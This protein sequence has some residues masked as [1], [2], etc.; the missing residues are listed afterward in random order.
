M[1]KNILYSG[2]GFIRLGVLGLALGLVSCVEDPDESDLY[3]FTGETIESFIE[4]DA[5]LT[6]FNYILQRVGMDRMM[7]SYGQYTCFA[8]TNEGVD[9]YIDSLWTDDKAIIPQ[10]GLLSNSLEGLTDS[11]CNEIARYHLTN[12][13][14]TTIDMGGAGAS[15][16]TM[17]GY[18]MSSSVDDNGNTVLNSV[19]VIYS[20]D[21][22]VSNGLVHK[23][24][25]VI[26]RST[27][28]LGDAL[29]REGGFTIF[30]EALMRTGL[31][32]SINA[33]VKDKKYTI[34]DYFDTQKEGRAPLYHPEECKIGYTIFAEPDSILKVKGIDSFPK[35]VEYANEVYG[36]ASSWY[37]YLNEMGITVNTGTTDE[38]FKQQ[39]NALHMFVAYHILHCSMAQDQLVFENKDGVSPTVSKWNYVNG[40]QPYDYYETFLPNTLVKIWQPLPDK[41]LYINRYLANNTLTD[42]VGTMGS[43]AMHAEGAKPGVKVERKDIIAHNGYIHPIN[44]LL[45]YDEDVPR[46]VLNE[47]LRFEATTFL[48]EF[49]NNGFRYM[50]IPEVAILNGGGSGARLA[51]PLD[52]FDNVVCYNEQTTLR[53]NVKGDYRLYQADSFQGWGQY[54]VAIK[55]PHVPTGNY[56]FRLLYSPMDHGGM[57][58]FYLGNSSDPQSM[59]PLDIPLDVRIPKD[60]P[61][62]GWTAFY[63][64]D[65]KGVASDIAM[66]NRGYMRGPCSFRGHPDGT[67]NMEANNGR[68]DNNTILRRILCRQE[69]V[70]SKDY[71]FRIKNVISDD[72]D[73]KWQLDFIEL[74]PLN[75]VDNNEFSEDWY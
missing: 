47:R 13:L 67:G 27:R 7:A 38:D 5:D 60:D 65:D 12:G 49:I 68:G 6:S 32:D 29:E 23:V 48:P 63:E 51:F 2:R 50:S 10:N 18:P 74:V 22:E 15:I 9:R 24:T 62:I 16:S 20:A 25:N 52:F 43:A 8:P 57:M 33:Y 36:N 19:A 44:D 69:F 41:N 3:T 66:R 56:E 34:T 46:K 39:F 31:V 72:T 26:P 1:K 70:Q 42:E 64:E 28:R 45:V 37:H 71:W 4:K 11:L 21:N 14:Y 30:H 61:R 40:G 54:D 58:Q 53:Y 55:L 17:R 75:V 35:L 73:L 59:L